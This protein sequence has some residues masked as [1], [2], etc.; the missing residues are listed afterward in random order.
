[1]IRVVPLVIAILLLGACESMPS[2]QA[3]WSKAPPPPPKFSRPVPARMLLLPIDLR[4]HQIS[5]GGVVEKVDT[6][7]RQAVDSAQAYMKAFDA[8]ED[9][10]TLVSL[11]DLAPEEQA[12]L[13]QHVALYDVVALT[14]FMARRST[15]PKWARRGTE[16]DF[17][18]G[19]GLRDLA[20]KSG[21]DAAMVIIGS[22]YISSGGRKAAMVLSSVTAALVGIGVVPQGGQSFVSAGVFDLRTGQLL[23]Y[24]THR[25]G[26]IDLDKADGVRAVLDAVFREYPA[27]TTPGTPPHAPSG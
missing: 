5:A 10:L 17:T 11:P 4:V 7:T 19:P 24:E 1:M 8:R 12:T 27:K 9:S 13:D 6:W 15:V 20:D 25:S 26:S 14:A 3:M 21:A 23:W 22:D 2:K 16:T 18:L